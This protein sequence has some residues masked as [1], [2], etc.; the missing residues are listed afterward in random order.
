MFPTIKDNILL[1]NE[2]HFILYIYFFLGK[3]TFQL[4]NY[5]IWIHSVINDSLQSLSETKIL[6]RFWM[7]NGSHDTLSLL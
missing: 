4:W 1:K 3:W 5:T 7:S 6:T 2:I